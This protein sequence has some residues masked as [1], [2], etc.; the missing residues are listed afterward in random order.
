MESEDD[1]CHYPVWEIEE[2]RPTLYTSMRVPCSRL[3]QVG[4]VLSTCGS[5]PVR[6]FWV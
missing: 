6:H 5:L 3:P 4:S 1:D 2:T